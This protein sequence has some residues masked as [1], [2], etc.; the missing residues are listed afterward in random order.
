MGTEIPQWK[1]R[2][3]FPYNFLG[4]MSFSMNWETTNKAT[5]FTRV[6][7]LENQPEIMS[8]ATENSTG[9]LPWFCRRGLLAQSPE[10]AP[11]LRK[12]ASVS[13]SLRVSSL[14]ISI[15][16]SHPLAN[17]LCVRSS[18]KRRNKKEGSGQWVHFI[19]EEKI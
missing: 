15:S 17:S 13:P 2:E 6:I 12:S 1:Y 10:I 4:I 16:Q 8:Q 11:N 19:R 9:S 5:Y 14:S 18:E 7:Y 3:K